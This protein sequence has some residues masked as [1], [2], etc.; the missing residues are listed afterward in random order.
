MLFEFK[1]GL[2]IFYVSRGLSYPSPDRKSQGK[3]EGNTDTI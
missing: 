1:T 3:Y 2:S